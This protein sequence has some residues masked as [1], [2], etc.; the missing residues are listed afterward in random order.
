MANVHT[1]GD[2][3]DLRLAIVPAAQGSANSAWIQ[4]FGGGAGND[5]AVF[6]LA[7]GAAADDV[8]MKVQQ[9]NTSGGGSPKDITGAA[10]TTITTTTDEVVV[11]ID[12]GSGDLDDVNGFRWVQAQVTVASGSPPYTV[13]FDGYRMRYPG[14]F[15]HDAS[16]AERVLVG[17]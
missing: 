1:F 14:N 15:T 6:I 5:R 12:F 13:L 17:F 7:I 9:A 11:T 10:I 8:D 3:N 2:N 4:P 16:Y